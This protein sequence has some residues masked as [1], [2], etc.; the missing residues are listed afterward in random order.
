[1]AS[2][3]PSGSAGGVVEITNNAI[4]PANNFIATAVVI[5]PQTRISYTFPDGCTNI[6]WRVRQL[7]VK[8]RFFSALN[9]T[10]YYTTDS[11]FS[12]AVNTKDVTFCWE[13]DT[14]IDIELT[15]W[16]P[17]GTSEPAGFL[18]MESGELL[19]FE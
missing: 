14:P 9:A 13:S 1:M 10:G 19:E 8:A 17:G 2:F 16:G 6:T 7:D 4:S 3:T 15:Y 11:Y 18:L 5:N 12:G